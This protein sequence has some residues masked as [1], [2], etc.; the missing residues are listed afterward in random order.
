LDV[1]EIIQCDF[2]KNKRHLILPSS[3]WLT[4]INCN[5]L[6]VAFLGLYASS[7]GFF[8]DTVLDVPTDVGPKTVYIDDLG[9]VN[10]DDLVYYILDK[11]LS[12]TS[13]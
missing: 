12:K 11:T 6:H 13:G 10:E 1:V 7:N 4:K 3:R 5:R 9:C 8:L 2:D